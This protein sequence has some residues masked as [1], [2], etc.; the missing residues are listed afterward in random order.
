[1]DHTYKPYRMLSDEDAP[2]HLPRAD[3]GPPCFCECVCPASEPAPQALRPP[4]NNSVRLLGP[5]E[6]K[7]KVIVLLKAALMQLF[8]E[9]GTQNCCLAVT[10]FAT[11]KA[12]LLKVE[13]EVHLTGRHKGKSKVKWRRSGVG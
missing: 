2:A 6:D 13:L 7:V 9:Q 3:P 12:V 5:V 10:A 4:L 1:M 8:M 11:S